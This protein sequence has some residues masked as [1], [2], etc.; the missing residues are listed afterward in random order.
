MN[1]SLRFFRSFSSPAT[2]HPICLSETPARIHFHKCF[3]YTTHL[4]DELP[5][6]SLSTLNSHLALLAR[7]SSF[8]SLWDLF[9]K[10]H[11]SSIHLDSYTFTPVLTACSA[12]PGHQRGRQVHAL[13]LKAGVGLGTISKTALMDMYSKYGY[14]DESVAVFREMEFPDVVSWNALISSYLRED[15]GKEALGAFV[16]M[17]D[18]RVE[19]SEFTLCS[20]VKACDLLKSWKKDNVM[21]NCLVSGCV[22][23]RRYKEAFGVMSMMRPN[24]VGLTTVLNAC[25]EISDLRTGMQVHCVAMRYGFVSQIQ[26]CN[27]LLDMYAKCGR[28]SKGRSVFDQIFSRDVVSWTTMIDAY[29]RH[30]YGLEALELFNQMGEEVNMVLPNSI[31]FLAVLSACGHAGLVNEGLQIFK[32]VKEKYGLDPSLEH[33]SCFIDVLGRA[34]WIEDAWSLYDDMIGHGI[35]PTIAIWASLLNVSSLNQDASRGE[36]AAKNL[37]ALEPN[38]PGINVLL[39]NFYASI[40]RWDVVDSLRSNMK[41]KGLSKESGSSRLSNHLC[42]S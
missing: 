36:F 22:K 26:L 25:S 4:F 31:T 23:N 32:L 12:L 27:A 34:G 42:T 10:M 1:A 29:G 5:H 3:C 18:R 41:D 15:L 19:F 37:L 24:S 17:R 9:R 11:S 14:L 20:V 40:T 8:L 2:I 30:G 7:G 39:S 35:R 21:W 13:M 28:I 33:Y 38:N 6:R 16:A